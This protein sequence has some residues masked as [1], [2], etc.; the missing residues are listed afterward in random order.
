M[1]PLP[2]VY[3][4]RD[5]QAIIEG[6]RWEPR[7]VFCTKTQISSNEHGIRYAVKFRRGCRES[8][9]ANI[10]ELV[11]ST[12]LRE[13]NIKTFDVALVSVSNEFAYSYNKKGNLGYNVDAGIHYGT[14]FNIDIDP[15]P[16]ILWEEMAAPQ[17][18]I[19]LWVADS[20]LMN[21]DREVHGNIAMIQNGGAFHLLA[22]DQSDCFLG[23]GR[24]AGGSCFR[25]CQKHGSAKYDGIFKFVDRAVGDY[26]CSR[27]HYTLSQ[28]QEAVRS[29]Q[30]AAPKVVEAVCLVPQDWWKQ[31][32]I[33]PHDVV[34]CLT[35]RANS[36]RRIVDVDR[37]EGMHRA[38]Q[39]HL[40]G[41]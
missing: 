29:V 7:K 21:I 3:A 34:S 1:Q 40:R 2:L 37:M 9:A 20:W 6:T 17:E 31:A 5:D 25:E 16:P 15:G 4:H 26:G 18:L 33:A 36:M 12:L 39:Q 27:L 38:I 23:S 22:A 10:S 30:K 32:Q 11:A 24:F 35:E 28:I 8:A 14:V 19:E 41:L 13:M